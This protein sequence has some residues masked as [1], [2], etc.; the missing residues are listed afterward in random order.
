MLI[1]AAMVLGISAPSTPC[2]AQ[3]RPNNVFVLTDDLD[4]S[5]VQFMPH[6]LEMERPGVSFANYFV[7]DSLCCP[8]RPSIFTGEFP[9]NSGVFR[10][11]K[12]DGGFNAQFIVH[13]AGKPFFIE[14]A[15]FAPHAPYVPTR[16][17][18]DAFPEV[19]PP[20]TPAFAAAPKS[21]TRKWLSRLPPL[22]KSDIAAIDRDFR[23]RAQSVL[24]V[25]RM[26]G[27]L[28]TAVAASGQRKTPISSSAPTTAITWVNTA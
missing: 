5:L 12:P 3:A 1:L 2:A 18:E 23:K 6:V 20:R 28:Q 7:T 27:D 8:S 25:D 17:D 21:D 24:A 14:V 4:L 19:R 10:N 22:S 16:R 11:L 9:H 13:S 15:T 26:I